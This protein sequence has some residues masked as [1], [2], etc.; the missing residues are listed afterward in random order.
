MKNLLFP[1]SIVL[2]FAVSAAS[3][4][5]NSNSRGDIYKINQFKA[6]AP[7]PSLSTELIVSVDNPINKRLKS[8]MLEVGDPTL[9][10]G[11]RF[12]IIS[13]D[14][15]EE[16]ELI[17]PYKFLADR[18]ATVHLVSPKSPTVPDIFGVAIPEIRKDHIL[19]VHYMENSGWIKIDKYLDEV[20]ANDYDAFIIP[21]GAW[22]PDGIRVNTNAQKMVVDANTQRKPIMAVCHGPL[23]LV[24]AGLIKGKQV[25]SFWNIQVDLQSAGA[26]WKDESCVV[27]GNIITG[28]YP[29]DLPDLMTALLKQ[30]GISISIGESKEN[31]SR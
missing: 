30:M 18:G 10:K 22:N 27:D 26:T 28:R 21:G 31:A 13:T 9:L 23:L 24:N 3:G 2:T 17:V 14:G 20:S 7:V 19:T 15:V 6:T 29:F 5:S 8:M 1:F 16:L 25:T 12:A 4:Q 11:K